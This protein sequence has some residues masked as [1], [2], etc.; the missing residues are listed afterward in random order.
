MIT[1]RGCNMS[2]DDAQNKYP[3]TDNRKYF[4]ETMYGDYRCQNQECVWSY[5]MEHNQYN[6]EE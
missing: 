2:Y 6:G 1:C 4:F 5:I 3:D